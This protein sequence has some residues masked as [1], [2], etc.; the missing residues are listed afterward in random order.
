MTPVEIVL[1]RL[2]RPT[3]RPSGGWS[4]KCPAH[5]GRGHTSLSIDETPDPSLRYIDTCGRGNPVF[6]ALTR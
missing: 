3:Q 6:A 2:R 4:A 1:S 5:E